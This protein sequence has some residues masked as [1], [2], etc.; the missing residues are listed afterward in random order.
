MTVKLETQ[1]KSLWGLKES[2]KSSK[3]LDF[4]GIIEGGFIYHQP[5]R[6]I[7]L[8]SGDY[9]LGFPYK[10]LKVISEDEVMVF[11][12]LGDELVGSIVYAEEEINQ[13]NLQTEDGESNVVWS[14]TQEGDYPEV[15]PRK[16]SVYEVHQLR[17]RLR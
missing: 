12:Y 4:R 15:P 14:K 2:E 11:E 8:D 10:G 5:H 7:V 3:V 17:L 13:Q 6:R 16:N 9:D 1:Q